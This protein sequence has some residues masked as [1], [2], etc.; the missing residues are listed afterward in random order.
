MFNQYSSSLFCIN[1]EIQ[2]PTTYMRLL[3][4]KKILACNEYENKIKQK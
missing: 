4:K 1:Y 3:L 2:T